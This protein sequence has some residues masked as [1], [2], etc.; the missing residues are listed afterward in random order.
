MIRMQG[1]AVI[2]VRKTACP[3]FFSIL[4]FFVYPGIITTEAVVAQ[5]NNSAEILDAY[6]DLVHTYQDNPGYKMYIDFFKEVY[7]KMHKNY[8]YEVTRED[9]SKFMYKFNTRIYGQLKKTGKSS[10]YVKWR[11]AAYLVDDL[12]DSGDTFS[13]FMPPKAAEKY[14]Q[15]ALGKRIDLGIEGELEAEGYRVTFVEIRSDAY[16]K[17]LRKDDIIRAIDDVKVPA[18]T[19]KEVKDL[20]VPLEGTK[21]VLRYFDDSEGIETTMEVESREYFKQ[22]VFMVPVDVPGVYCIELQKFNRKT[23]EDMERFMAE[24]LEEKGTGLIIDLR[25][26][27]GGPPLAAREISAF[28]LPS[29]HAFAYFERKN[30]PRANLDIP[31]I[32]EEY[33]YKGDIVILVNEK[34]GSASELFTGILQRRARATVMGTNTAGKVLLKSMFYFD[35]NSMVLL[36]TARGFHPDGTVFSFDG[37]TPDKRIGDEEPDLIQYAANYLVN[38]RQER[39]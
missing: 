38:L 20:L 17:G 32:P 35:D 18:L 4:F 3:L 21:V 15:T 12:K 34:S 6:K 39:K 2:L 24:I 14:E 23:G 7:L 19:D 16:E 8:Y 1:Q 22:G 9:F 13:A 36:V 31:E 25:G 5:K 11:S 33:H 10:D 29:G 26:N 27:P 37:V 28:F 30:K